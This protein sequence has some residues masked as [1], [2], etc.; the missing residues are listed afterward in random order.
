MH[1]PLPHGKLLRQRPSFLTRV[2]THHP[3]TRSIASR[4]LDF[5]EQFVRTT[6]TSCKA[7]RFVPSC[8]P[9]RVGRAGSAFVFIL[10]AFRWGEPGGSGGVGIGQRRSNQVSGSAKVALHCP[11]EENTARAPVPSV[12]TGFRWHRAPCLEKMEVHG[13]PQII[14]LGDCASYSEATFQIFCSV[15][16]LLRTA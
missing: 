2:A 1:F 13:G 10:F 15:R 8:R 3:I 7:G 14:K 16:Q 12:I 4:R 5:V 11:D 9:S 6:L